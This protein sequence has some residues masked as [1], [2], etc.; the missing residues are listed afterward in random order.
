MSVWSLAAAAIIAGSPASSALHLAQEV[1]DQATPAPVVNVQSEKR[2]TISFNHAPVSDVLDWMAKNGA[3]FVAADSELPKDATITLNV[4]D[5]PMNQV[6]DAIA[7]ALGGHWDRRGGMRVFRQGEGFQVF[8]GDGMSWSDG[9]R[10]NLFQSL[11]KI[12]MKDGDGKMFQFT[13]GDKDMKFFKDG[14]SGKVF[15]F[16]PGD[17]GQWK[18]FGDGDKAKIFMSPDVKIDMQKLHEQLKELHGMDGKTWSMPDMPNMAQLKELHDMDG[19]TWVMP[20]MPELKNFQGMNEESRKEME[21]AM[22]AARKAMHDS[23]GQMKISQKAMED[24]RKAMEKARK[25]HPEAFK[26]G[27]FYMTPKDGQSWI[28]QDGKGAKDFMPQVW[29]ARSGGDMT[30][31]LS[32]LSDEQ[33]EKQRRQGYLHASDLTENQRK[34]LGVDAK[35]KGWSITISK[36]GESLTV[37]SDD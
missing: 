27:N 35:G 19:K 32:S 8:D 23:Q 30:K 7:S 22:E 13:P 28:F 1:Q 31:I 34:M 14:S 5:Q 12:N 4:Q 29:T 36:N 6:L 20:D 21:K 2:V 18:V 11:P 15:Q 25:E 37:K 26:N 10:E 3:S 16:A 24:A 17:K 9:D 33:R